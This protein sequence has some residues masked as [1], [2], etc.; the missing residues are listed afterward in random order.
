MTRRDT[1]VPKFYQNEEHCQQCR[2]ATQHNTGSA[3]RPDSTRSGARRKPVNLS[4]LH[5]V[6]N[7]TSQQG[8]SSASKKKGELRVGDTM[9]LQSCTCERSEPGWRRSAPAGCRQDTP[10]LKTTQPSPQSAIPAAGSPRRYVTLHGSVLL[11]VNMVVSKNGQR[12]PQLG[13]RQK[14]AARRKR[15]PRCK[16]SVKRPRTDTGVFLYIK[17]TGCFRI[18]NFRSLYNICGYAFYKGCATHAVSWARH[19]KSHTSITK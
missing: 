7:D 16:H 18:R 5:G 19:A 17:N 2:S 6:A 14:C 8:R 11:R 12:I 9:A 15:D 4:Q 13:Q 1:K 3:P 10:A